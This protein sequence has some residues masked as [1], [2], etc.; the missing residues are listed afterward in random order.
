VSGAL[1]GDNAVPFAVPFRFMAVG[2]LSLAG[3][4]SALA[5]Q[6]AWAVAP[7]AHPAVLALVHVLT[8]MFGAGVLMGALHQLV[9]VLL[10]AKLHAP[11]WGGVTW[12]AA[13]A[14][15]VLIVTGFALGSRPSFLAVGGGLALLA[16]T[17]LLANLALT[18]A[19]ATRIDTVAATVLAA[20]VALWLT[21]MLGLL[22]ALS[23]LLPALAPAFAAVRPLH[24]TLG[25]LAAFGLAIAAAGHRL[26]AMFVLSH[27]APLRW[28]RLMAG[29]V[30]TA[31]IVSAAA[32]WLP[33]G[34][35]RPWAGPAV[36]LAITVAALAAVAD[37]RAILVRRMR[38]RPDVAVSTFLLGAAL[39]LAPVV[40]LL[41][42]RP[43]DA[44]ASTLLGP[45]SLAI[46][47][48]LVKIVGFLAWQH[49]YAP[50]VGRDPAS[51]G[52]VPMLAD[53]TVPLL[54][55]L[56]AAGLTVGAFAVILARL[57]A[58]AP[59][60]APASATLTLVRS[61]A[62]VGA[63]AAWSLAAHLGWIVFGRHRSSHAVS[64]RDFAG[65]E[66][67]TS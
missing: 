23:R 54:G 25:L 20:A 66:T 14:G 4:W 13:T 62:L 67:G 3:F 59:R 53:M 6:P 5:F 30:A 12:A 40:L 51:A 45:V 34:V 37:V 43:H 28:L 64:V 1:A 7:A 2:A 65:A 61:G 52:G 48:M 15:G 39:A 8:L 47:G 33:A 44:V 60:Y 55:R 56:T 31:V 19:K 32:A 18:A 10:V 57:A 22:I 46:A 17:V 27:G 29:A 58:A 9:P 11:S 26:L 50:Q 38:K 21:M 16:T 36:T 42:G 63:I 49:R 35:P 24:L 41:L